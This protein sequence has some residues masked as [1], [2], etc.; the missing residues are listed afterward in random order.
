MGGREEGR[1]KEVFIHKETG[2]APKEM[3]IQA[4]GG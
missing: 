2:R 1:K 3:R 4:D